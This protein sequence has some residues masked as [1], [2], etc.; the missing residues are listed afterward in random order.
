[1]NTFCVKKA[2]ETTSCGTMYK[3]SAVMRPLIESAAFDGE[4]LRRV[5]NLA[6]LT[7]VKMA[8][9]RGLEPLLLG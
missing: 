1:M 9:P 2:N 8:S 6:T 5:L 7:G 3:R 4:E